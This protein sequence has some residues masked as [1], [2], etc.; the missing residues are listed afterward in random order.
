MMINLDE[1]MKD[2]NITRL[3]KIIKC[4]RESDNPDEIGKI[5]M[6]MDK[7]LAESDE[8]QMCRLDRK[9]DYERE[10]QQKEV[11]LN[12]AVLLRK[13]TKRWESFGIESREYRKVNEYVKYIRTRIKGLK[14]NVRKAEKDFDEHLKMKQFV[15][16][17]YK[18]V[19]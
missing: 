5:R 11:E 18:F 13:K 1:V 14:S 3:R 4:I 15:Q 8:A 9:K 10:I 16:K 2:K 12:Q 17:A 6:W 19:E 7:F